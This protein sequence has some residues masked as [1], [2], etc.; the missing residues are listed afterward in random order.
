MITRFCKKIHLLSLHEHVIQD[1]F[2]YLVYILS[3]L[4]TNNNLHTPISQYYLKYEVCNT[5]R[6]LVWN[7]LCFW[8]FREVVS[9]SGYV[10]VSLFTCLE[11]SNQIYTHLWVKNRITYN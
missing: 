8:P 1:N 2:H 10:A 11:W 5:L 9:Q 7:G 3:T 6:T 4:V